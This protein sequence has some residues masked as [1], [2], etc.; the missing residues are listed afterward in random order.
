MG[1][2]RSRLENIDRKENKEEEEEEEKK[3]KNCV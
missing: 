3:M 1:K 2:N